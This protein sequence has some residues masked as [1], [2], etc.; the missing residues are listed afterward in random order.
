MSTTN[1]N[2]PF[3][4]FEFKP[5]T[6]GLGF[7]RKNEKN[8]I[9]QNP[10]T[11]NSKLEFRNPNLTFEQPTPVK[12]KGLNSPLPRTAPTTEQTQ[13]A[14][15]PSMNIPTIEDDS[16][17][18]AQTAVNDILKSLNQKKQQEEA[19]QRNKKRLIW[20]ETAPSLTAGLLDAMLVLAGFL[21]CLI[22]MLAITQVDL[23]ANMTNPGPNFTIYWA[24]LSL[25]ACV[26]LIYN[27]IFRAYLGY[28]PGEWAFDQRCGSELEQ[29]SAM[30]V[31]KVALRTVIVMV[32]GFLP[33][34]LISMI[35]GHDAI[36]S[37]TGLTIQK[38]TY[39]TH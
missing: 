5:L 24:T 26:T 19:L 34:S 29:A 32:T 1:T 35:M 21:L 36:G 9:A 38:Q 39:G 14:R 25:L 17:T 37:I 30:Y 7:H 20:K 33:L 13:Q 22:A 8:K 11:P 6:E 15:R 3:E 28:T 16:I 2:D 4:E 27:V 23:I 18:K 12:A 10:T 31:G